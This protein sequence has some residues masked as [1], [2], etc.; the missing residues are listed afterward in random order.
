MEK[1]KTAVGVFAGL[2]K[3]E[4]GKNAGKL[5]LRRRTEIPSIIPGKSFKGNWEL[6][7]GGVME[8]EKVPYCHL[9]NELKREVEEETG[10]PIAIDPMPPMYPVLFKGPEGYDLAL[11][12]PIETSLE[13]TKGETIWVNVEELNKLAREFEPADKKTGKDGKGL[14][15]GYGK[16]MHCMA[17]RALY[18]SPNPTYSEDAGVML[19]EIQKGWQR[20]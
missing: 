1:M 7:G 6:P 3:Q 4:S 14:L 11:V 16:R 17:L 5:L 20:E 10:I 9:V 12:T 2:L 15:G 19:I 18:F 13:S 8:A